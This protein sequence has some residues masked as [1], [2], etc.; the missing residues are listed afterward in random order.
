MGESTLRTST[1]TLATTRQVLRATLW[2]AT[3]A[4][5]LAVITVTTYAVVTAIH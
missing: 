1:R 2:V 5:V 3:S 4:L